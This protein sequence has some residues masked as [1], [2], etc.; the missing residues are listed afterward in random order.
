[1]LRIS[2][3]FN[4]LLI[5]A[6]SGGGYFYF[7][8]KESWNT[9]K[10]ELE[11]NIGKLRGKLVKIQEKQYNIFGA[12]K[13]TFKEEALFNEQYDPPEICL[14]SDDTAIWVKCV[15]L[16]RKALHKWIEKYRA[17]L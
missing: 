3:L 17:D 4:I 2:I 6:I 8:Q 15:D 14:G 13:P 5:C 7:Q 11:K 10:S 9:E 12:P 16:R 1:M